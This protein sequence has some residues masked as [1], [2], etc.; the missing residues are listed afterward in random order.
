M[1]KKEGAGRCVY[2]LG[3]GSVLKVPQALLKK[4]P[5]YDQN[6]IELGV[7]KQENNHKF[8]GEILEWFVEK[9]YVILRMRRYPLYRKKEELKIS[10][11]FKEYIDYLESEYKLW[12]YELLRWT[13]LSSDGHIID[14]GHL[15]PKE[16]MKN[17]EHWKAYTKGGS[18]GCMERYPW[19]EI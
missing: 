7:W 1:Q 10:S 15:Y 6:L 14:Y 3:D 8:L 12:R 4:R 18:E 5:I 16:L 2:D 11:E 9:E 19:L 17:I 13:N